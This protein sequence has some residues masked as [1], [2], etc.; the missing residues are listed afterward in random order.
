M[1]SAFEKLLSSLL[2]R[3]ASLFATKDV[4][5]KFFVLDSTR[6]VLVYN[7]EEW[8]D[9]LSLNRN[10]QLS[11]EVG[12]F[13]DSKVTTLVQIEIVE[14]LFE[15]GRVLS[16]QLKDTSLNLAEQVGDCLLGD[17]GILFLWNLPGRFHH[18]YKVFI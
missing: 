5:L 18:P 13:I 14:D 15:E 9:I 2:L 3:A 8:V 12:N 17:C 7:L 10:F 1:Q 16:G 4:S 11:D 6:V